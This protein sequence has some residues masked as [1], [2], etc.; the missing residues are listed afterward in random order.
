MSYYSSV[1]EDIILPSFIKISLRFARDAEDV[2][3]YGFGG[4]LNLM[5]VG[6][7][8]PLPILY[9]G[10]KRLSVCS[11]VNFIEL[12]RQKEGWRGISRPCLEEGRLSFYLYSRGGE[13]ARS[14]REEQI[15][16]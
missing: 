11:A 16:R 7:G 2:V 6:E 3:P 5:L 12:I 14:L 15:P 8:F 13:T 4:F 9:T 1:G 10:Q